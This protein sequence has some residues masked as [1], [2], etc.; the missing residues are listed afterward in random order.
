MSLEIRD[1]VEIR[2]SN[3]LYK[4]GI[5]NNRNALNMILLISA[6]SSIDTTN[7]PYMTNGTSYYRITKHKLHSDRK[8]Y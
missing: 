5:L 1:D 2:F 6:M 7:K 4:T 3:Y 8:V